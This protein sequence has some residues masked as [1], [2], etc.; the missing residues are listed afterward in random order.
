[1]FSEQSDVGNFYLENGFLVSL[2]NQNTT[3]QNL[4]DSLVLSMSKANNAYLLD[5]QTSVNQVAELMTQHHVTSVMITHQQKLCGIVTDR[6]FCTKVVAQN[7]DYSSPVENTMKPDPISIAHYK[8][9][10]EAM[11]LMANAQ[12]RHLFIIK[13]KQVV[14]VVTIADLLRKQSHNVVFLINEIH[15]AATLEQLVKISK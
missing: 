2:K 5:K 9:G 15:C 11:L 3:Q 1:M 8:S 10:M 12:I 4:L 14:G 6:A 13:N 7:I